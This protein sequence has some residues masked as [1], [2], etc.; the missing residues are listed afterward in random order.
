MKRAPDGMRIV[1]VIGVPEPRSY[2]SQEHERALFV[3]VLC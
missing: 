3:L 2:T 1:V